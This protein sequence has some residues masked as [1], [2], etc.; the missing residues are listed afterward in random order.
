MI[1][2]LLVAIALTSIL[3]GCNNESGSKEKESEVIAPPIIS[4][5]V[6]QTYPHDTSSYTQ[7]LEWHNNE[8]FES[9]G[10][11]GFSKLL[12]VNLKDGKILQSHSLAK[13]YFG[14]GMTILNNKIYQ[15]T[16]QNKKGFVYDLKTFSTIQE[17]EWPYEGWGLT[18]NGKDL[19][20]STGSNV[21]YRVDPSS[22]KILEAISVSNQYGPLS[23][24]NELE[25]V[26]GFIYANIYQTDKI[27]KIDPINGKVVGEMYFTDILQKLN[28]PFDAYK[29]DVLNGIAFNPTNGNFFVTGKYWPA[30]IE[31]SLLENK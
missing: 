1:R 16:W 4:Y 11:Y 30:L 5:Q 23:N 26:N 8:L 9:T 24:I 7:G 6:V 19:L 22:F 21:I 18:N 3:V 12:K 2:V 15:L 29:A 25:W 20:V 31:I 27:V 17:F 13:E 10:Q 28:I 14:E